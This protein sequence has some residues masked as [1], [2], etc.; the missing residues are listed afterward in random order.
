MTELRANPQ[1]SETPASG[2]RG[3][4]TVR[5][6]RIHYQIITRVGG[7]E[8]IRTRPDHPEER[9]WLWVDYRQS[10]L[11]LLW[12]IRLESVLT[13]LL[14]GTRTSGHRYRLDRLAAVCEHCI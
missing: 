10:K 1:P 11:S 8:A 2:G 12:S 5:T 14:C 3:N 4:S 9:M 13:S 6:R 7:L